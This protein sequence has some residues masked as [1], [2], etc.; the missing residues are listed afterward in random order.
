MNKGTLL[1]LF[2][3]LMAMMQCGVA[4]TVQ[5]T[6]AV[7]PP[8]SKSNPAQCYPLPFASSSNT[9]ELTVANTATIALAGVNVEATNVPSWLKF[10]A[11]EQHIAVLKANQEMAATFTF[12]VEKTA[13]VQ[14]NQTLKFV[15][16]APSGEKW[17]KEITVAVA[18]P[19]KF[20]VYQNYPNPFNP[21]TTISYQLTAVSRV[22]LRI[23]NLLGQVVAELVDGDRLPGYHQETWDATRYSS[24]VYVYQLIAT[25]DHGSKQIA[26]KRMLLLK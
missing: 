13:P 18:P 21:S 26:H 10:V 14:K 1:L 4:Q 16:S 11:T 20:E 8:A 22:S 12:A 19:T 24:G 2:L 25:D 17:T 6:N 15:I 9:I 7:T 3:L 5:N 23:Y